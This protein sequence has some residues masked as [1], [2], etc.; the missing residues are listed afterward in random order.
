MRHLYYGLFV[1]DVYLLTTLGP[2][3]ALLAGG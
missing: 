3:F 2:L 1:V